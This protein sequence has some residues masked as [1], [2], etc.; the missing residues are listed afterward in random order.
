MTERS[1][2]DAA[3]RR[4]ALALDALAAAVERRHEADRGEQALDAQL[5]ALHA[6]RPRLA[7]ELDAAVARSPAAGSTHHGGGPRRE[8]AISNLPAEAAADARVGRGIPH[9]R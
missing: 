5:H 3:S 8:A 4:L 2:I 1:A 9:V 6:D 7:S